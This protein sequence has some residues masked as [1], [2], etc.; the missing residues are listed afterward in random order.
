[1]F[2]AVHLGYVVVQTQHLTDW[3][4]FGAD[5]IG[6]HVDEVTADVLRFRLDDRECRFLIQRGPREDLT[7]MG[8]HVDDHETSTASSS[9]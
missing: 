8:W 3:R 7:A 5:A 6:L 9:A 2:G 4:R 1:V